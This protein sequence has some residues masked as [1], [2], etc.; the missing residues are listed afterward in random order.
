[1]TRKKTYPGAPGG[2]LQNAVKKKQSIPNVFL[3]FP[4]FFGTAGLGLLVVLNVPIKKKWTMILFLFVYDILPIH[5]L[6]V[7]VGSFFSIRKRVYN[8][9]ES[10]Y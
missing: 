7:L 6:Y 2:S 9:S 3:M 1:M 10:F 8:L 5:K 4:F